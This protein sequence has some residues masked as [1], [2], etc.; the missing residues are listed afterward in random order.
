MTKKLILALALAIA[1]GA[2]V[3]PTPAE[4][5]Q[6]WCYNCQDGHCL[7]YTQNTAN[8]GWKT[9]TQHSI[10]GYRYCRVSNPCIRSETDQRI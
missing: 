10:F 5:E 6:P 4:A 8:P 3:A 2:A 1:V 9:C 7:K